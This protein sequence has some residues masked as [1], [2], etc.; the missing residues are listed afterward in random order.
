MLFARCNSRSDIKS[1]TAE[2]AFGATQEF[3]GKL[4]HA[5]V[6]H[7]V[8]SQADHRVAPHLRNHEA[9]SQVPIPLLNPLQFLEILTVPEVRDFALL[10]KRIVHRP[11]HLSF[12]PGTIRGILARR[13]RVVC[14]LQFPALVK[15][16]LPASARA[17]RA[18]GG[19]FRPHLN[20]RGSKY[21]LSA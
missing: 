4:S 2:R 20:G 12:N 17:G 11:W 1:W 6:I 19:V 10:H 16:H 15:I 13:Q 7:S 14:C 8:E 5:E 9:A 18:T 21:A 3:A